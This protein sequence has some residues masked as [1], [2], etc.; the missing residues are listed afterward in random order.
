MIKYEDLYI[1]TVNK[2]KEDAIIAEIKDC[3]DNG[4]S[5]AFDA[6]AGA[7]KTFSLVKT[8]E[9]VIQRNGIEYGKQG[10]KI[11]CIT[12]T[13]AAVNE[14]NSRLK[15]TPLVTVS[16]IHDRLWDIIKPYRKLLLN[17]HKSKI[18]QELQKTQK[19]LNNEPWAKRYADLDDDAKEKFKEIIYKPEIRK[20]FYSAYDKSAK[21]IKDVFSNIVE[22]FPN[23]I[24][25]VRYFKKIVTNLYSVH[26][27]SRALEAIKN[28][29]C[30]AVEYDPRLN[31]DRLSKMKISHDTL[32]EYSH[33]IITQN[34]LLKQIICDQYPVMLIDEF[35]DTDSKVIQ[36]VA[37]VER[38]ARKINHPFIVGYYG[39]I[40]QN[41]YGNGV[42]KKLYVLHKGLRRICKTFNRRSSPKV[43]RV[44]NLIRNDGL[45]QK[46]IYSTFP[47]SEVLYSVCNEDGRDTIVD[48]LC[49]KWNISADNPLHCFELTNELVANKSGFENIYNFFKQARYYKR[50]K[51]YELL[52]EHVLA[53]DENKLGDIQKALFRFLQFY[54]KTHI[55]STSFNELLS[56]NRLDS[57]LK[58]QLNII[59]IRAL[60]DKIWDLSGV[61]L[62]EY[63][64]AVFAFYQQGDELYDECIRNVF[65][66]DI[67]SL[68]SLKNL[69]QEK[70][71][72]EEDDTSL[73]EEEVE[74]DRQKI[75]EFFNM[76]MSI[77]MRWYDYLVED[78]VAK[79][80]VFHTFHGTK[81]LEFDNVAIFM[82]S[83]FGTNSK[84]FSNLMHALENGAHASTDDKDIGSARN[85]L[86]VAVTRAVK[87]L[88]IVYVVNSS[89]Q[90]L[91]IQD[92]MQAIF[93][94]V[95]VELDLSL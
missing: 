45:R 2:N 43:I 66:E 12:Y 3:I 40:R 38:Y 84:Y 25:D 64:N 11:L 86:Y 75:D 56:V 19:H 47:Q 41:I 8:I 82:T 68:E 54:R 29:N 62:A 33:G 32:L 71:F 83:K 91:D 87:N 24:S 93:G 60:R 65:A 79:K 7:G 67:N 52:R 36:T 28:K 63:T 21:E 58:N 88:C 81:G 90:R 1:P 30:P 69:I 85:L 4:K 78:F 22:L 73:T 89:E 92:K 6:G 27:L 44:A 70:I 53:Q 26:N 50:G 94:E 9:A 59:N 17:Q 74:Q 61:S 51:N 72:S 55:D 35:Q 46:S 34:D 14:V 57:Q 20:L 23:V 48:D 31:S 16:T 13:N 49:E 80:K 5:W 15:N 76:E 95:G 37:S 18:L 77:F 10:Q 39:D 42:G